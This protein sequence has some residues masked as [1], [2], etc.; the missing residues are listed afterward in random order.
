[1][2]KKQ[3]REESGRTGIRDVARLAGVSP[4]TVSRVLNQSDKVNPDTR[5][6]IQAVIDSA[7][8]VRDGVARSL[9]SKRTGSVAVIV[10][11]LGNSVYAEAVDAIE[12]RLQLGR[13]HLLTANCGYD[14]R[15]EYEL[16]RTLIEHGVDGLV[17]V[18]NDHVPELYDLLKRSGIPAIQTFID[19]PHSALPCVG[20]DNDGPVRELVRYVADLGHRDFAVLH[21][22]VRHNDRIAIRLRAILGALEERGIKVPPERVIEAGYTVAEGRAGM[23]ALLLRHR[24]FTAVACTGDVLAVG[25]VIEARS[26]GIAIPGELSITGFHDYDMAS[27]IEP[28]LTTVHAP[29]REMSVAAAEYLL[30]SIAGENPPHSRQ[31]PTALVLRKS[32]G[33]A[34]R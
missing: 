32:T 18:G 2:R 13:Y 16:A 19:D 17:L 6:R 1:M 11:A 26:S 14:P 31:L 4:A 20:F 33:P 15:R 9:T 30:S 12:R 5:K 8:Y 24:N 29:L 10:P 25:A 23:R 7:N 22:P 34:P 28:P 27:Q 21:S 3:D